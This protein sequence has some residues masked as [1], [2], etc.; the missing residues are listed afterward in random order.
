L[1]PSFKEDLARALHQS[2]LIAVD[3]HKSGSTNEAAMTLIPTQ[4]TFH[5]LSHRD[6]I[7]S[8]IRGRVKWL[9]Q[10]YPGMVR[11]RVLV[12]V[13]HRHRRSGRHFHI[14]IEMT[15]AG[16]A[17]LVVTH[18][19]SLHGPTKDA[20]HNSLHKEADVDDAHRYAGV[21]IREAFDRAR[22]QLEDFAREQRA[23]VKTHSSEALR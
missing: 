10:F 8:D 3:S 4:V 21:A 23:C 19:P 7:E 11:C 1:P 12:E 18:E 17:P 22:R 9:E 14:R 20:D 16:G 13:P 5:G 6:D 15:V 2:M